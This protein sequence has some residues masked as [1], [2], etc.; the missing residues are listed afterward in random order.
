MCCYRQNNKACEHCCYRQNNKACEHF[1]CLHSSS[2]IRGLSYHVGLSSTTTAMSSYSICYSF[3]SEE[4]T[5]GRHPLGCSAHGRP[6]RLITS[7]TSPE[8]QDPSDSN[9]E[10]MIK[11]KSH[12]L[13][14]LQH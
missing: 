4:Q 9:G 6:I 14:D 11:N 10:I 5:H 12:V 3:L 7:R 1:T 13:A 2:G 8:I